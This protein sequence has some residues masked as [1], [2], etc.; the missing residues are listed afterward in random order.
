[1]KINLGLFSSKGVQEAQLCEGCTEKLF[2]RLEVF[3]EMHRSQTNS[4]YIVGHIDT[5][6][7]EPC[8]E[9]QQR[10]LE[11]CIAATGGMN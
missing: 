11:Q 2:N 8:K 1:V 9:C 6:H 7:W 3:L 4:F 10:F 5:I